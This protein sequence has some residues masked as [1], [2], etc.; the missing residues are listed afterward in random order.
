MHP[1]YA[2]WHKI[3]AP[4]GSCSHWHLTVRAYT[5]SIRI[6]VFLA[7]LTL[8]EASWSMVR[9]HLSRLTFPLEFTTVNL[10]SRVPQKFSN[11]R[12]SLTMMGDRHCNEWCLLFSHD[13]PW[14]GADEFRTVISDMTPFNTVTEGG[15][16]QKLNN[17]PDNL[18][19]SLERN[20]SGAP[21]RQNGLVV[22]R[23]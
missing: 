1:S 19:L 23:R 16:P 5:L 12:R 21:N 6:D 8:R 22:G 2:T 4:A 17:F 9:A 11:L 20:T 14:D 3:Y 10:L 15:H 18:W 13:Y 7:T